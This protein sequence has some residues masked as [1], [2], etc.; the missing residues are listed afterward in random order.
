MSPLSDLGHQTE[1]NS[2]AVQ[3]PVDDAETLGD[4]AR[5]AV[6]EAMAAE[7]AL[8]PEPSITASGNGE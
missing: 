5:D 1:S 2:T 6:N 3:R 8:L 7:I 4:V